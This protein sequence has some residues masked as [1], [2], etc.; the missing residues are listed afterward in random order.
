MLKII[1]VS[2]EIL[3]IFNLNSARNMKTMSLKQLCL[4]IYSFNLIYVNLADF[5]S[6]PDIYK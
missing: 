6:W 1:H 2:G 4:D 3:Q 5:A